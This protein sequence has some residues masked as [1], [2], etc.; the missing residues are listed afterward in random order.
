MIARD[1]FI[2]KR[3]RI[4]FENMLKE[5]REEGLAEGRREIIEKILRTLRAEGLYSDEQTAQMFGVPIEEVRR[6]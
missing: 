3:A 6:L 2:N 1:Y 4:D 5:V